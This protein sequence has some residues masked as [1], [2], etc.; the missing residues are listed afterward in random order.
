MITLY[1][2]T[3]FS[4]Q[5]YQNRNSDDYDIS[6]TC[7]TDKYRVLGLN[8]DMW[9]SLKFTRNYEKEQNLKNIILGDV[10]GE[11]DFCNIFYGGIDPG[12]NDISSKIKEERPLIKLSVVHGYSLIDWCGVIEGATKLHTVSTSLLFII[13]SIRNNT[14]IGTREAEKLVIRNDLKE[15]GKKIK[16]IQHFCFHNNLS[17]LTRLLGKLCTRIFWINHSSSPIMKRINEFDSKEEY[18]ENQVVDSEDEEDGVERN[19]EDGVE[20][21]E[22]DGVERNEENKEREIII[23]EEKKE[24]VISV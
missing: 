13:Q 22:E 8:T 19:E 10:E 18:Y 6:R 4:E 24:I 14:V 3:R 1:L 2:P 20:R 12:S 7:M 11:Y 21:N 16:I 15:F 9:K 23:I 5:I 17:N